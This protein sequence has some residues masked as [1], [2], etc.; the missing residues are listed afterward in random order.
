[1]QFTLGKEAHDRLRHAEALLSHQI[2]PGDIA[3]VVDRALKFF[4]SHLE[5]RKFGATDRP[6][7]Q[8]R[9]SRNPRYVP[10]HVKRAVCERDGERCTFVSENGHRCEARTHLEFDHIEEV[11]RGGGATVSNIRLRCRTHNQYTAERAFGAGF[12]EKKRDEARRAAE[13]KRARA[14]AEKRAREEARAAEKEARFAAAAT[15]RAAKEAA[16]AEQ[17]ERKARADQVIPA[18]RAL[19]FRVE[20]AQ[21]GAALCDDMPDAP[22]EDRVRNALSG[23]TR[24]RFLRITQ[25]PD[26]GRGLQS[27]PAS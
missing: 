27:A 10:A 14:H 9:A 25:K 12:M 20:E 1:V 11:A 23:L 2:R 16:V 26:Q 5:R 3:E 19:G 15:E 8:R 17:A 21:R 6:R 22:L 18:L 7:Q 13:E 4:V 24:E